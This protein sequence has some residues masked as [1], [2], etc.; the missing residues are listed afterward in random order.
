[1]KRTIQELV[2][3]VGG[4]SNP[5]KMPGF[6]YGTPAKDC[7][8][9]SIL[10]AAGKH[11]VCG[12]C[13]AHKGTYVFPV[14]KE[15][16]A[17][18]LK[19]LLTDLEQWRKDMTELLSRKYAKREKVFRWHDSGDLQGWEHLSA[20]V[21]IAND[22]PDFR[23]WLP[24]KEYDL[25]RKWIRVFGSFPVNLAVRVSAPMIGKEMP[26]IP[27]TVSSTVN[28]HEGYSCPAY[29]QDGECKDC[30]ACWSMEVPSVD[31]PKH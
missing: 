7:P 14:V 27:G 26:P 13:Y 31:Y 11:T 28:T 10:R 4:L 24:T 15:A 2:A 20:I 16:Q 17:R 23:F 19:I 9:G 30:R 18:R 29:T 22:L 3:A 1:M 5:S 6:S 25:I 21:Q 8:V 12:S